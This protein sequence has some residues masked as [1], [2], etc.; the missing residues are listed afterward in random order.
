MSDFLVKVTPRHSTEDADKDRAQDK[1]AQDGLQENRILNLAERGFLDPDLAVEDLAHEVALTVARHPR[2]VLPR[3]GRLARDGGARD[4]LFVQHVLG[5]VAEE[6][7]G[8]HV[9]VV[10]PV[11]D[12]AHAFPGGDQRRDADEPA[13]EGDYAPCS[14]GGAEGEEEVCD[15]AGQDAEDTESAGEDDP[16][17]V[18]VADCPADEVGVCL[19]AQGVFDGGYHRAESG[20][21]S[22]GL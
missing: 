2:L 8:S 12:D 7:P 6:F 22:G 18:A 10:H 9:P 17:T 19:L 16:R 21:V 4:G 11:Q 15:Q 20:R 1:R 3:I 13:H 5:L 14:A